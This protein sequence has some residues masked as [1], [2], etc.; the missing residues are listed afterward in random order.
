MEEQ[1]RKAAFVTSLTGYAHFAGEGLAQIAI[2]GRSNVGK[3]SLINRLCHNNKL[4]RTSQEPGKTRLINVFVLNEKIHLMDLPGYGY[5]RVSKGMAMDWGRMMQSYLD[6]STYLKHVLLLVDIRH[7]PSKE[8]VQMAAY[9]HARNL[10]CTVIATKADKCSR[11]QQN[12]SILTICR[13]LAVQ[14]WQVV[15]FSSVNGQG[16]E[17]VARRILALAQEAEE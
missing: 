11:A 10:P 5:A 6:Q 2:A 1:I 7:E 9:I 17:E 8:D 13:T 15:A 3:S 16:K 14:P 12:Q 4:A